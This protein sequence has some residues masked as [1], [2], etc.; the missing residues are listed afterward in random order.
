GGYGSEHAQTGGG[1]DSG[2]H[3]HASILAGAFGGEHVLDLFDRLVEDLAQLAHRL[4]VDPAVAGGAVHRLHEPH[5]AAA[6]LTQLVGVGLPGGV[7][8]LVVAVAYGLAVRLA[9]GA[10]GGGDRVRLPALL[11]GAGDQAGL[12]EELERRVDHSR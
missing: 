2:G 4:R 1:A 12:V 5:E 10:A 9:L 8:L 11:L 3:T 6:E 7:V